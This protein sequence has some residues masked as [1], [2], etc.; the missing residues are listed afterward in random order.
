M[1]AESGA[2]V[3]STDDG[4]AVGRIVL[5]SYGWRLFTDRPIGYGL[6]FDSMAHSGDYWEYFEYYANAD[7]IRNYSVHNY[8]L[9]ILDKYG[10]G[11]LLAGVLVFPRRKAD[12]RILL[13]MIAY[14]VHISFHN[15]GPMQADFF[16]WYVLAM[17]PAATPTLSKVLPSLGWRDGDKLGARWRA[18][19]ANQR[20]ARAPPD[21]A[22]PNGAPSG[23]PV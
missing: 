8:F 22:S 20:A 14:I 11:A 10:V 17:F 15:D 6:G 9:Q 21:D 18:S 1:L 7:A 23:G 16:I 19:L 2:R 13:P 4:S 3:A 5:S 12:F